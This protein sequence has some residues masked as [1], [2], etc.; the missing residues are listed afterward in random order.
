KL[1]PY[2][3]EL[4]FFGVMPQ[5]GPDLEHFLHANS[6]LRSFLYVLR[7]LFRQKW[8]ELRYGRGL[9][10]SNGNALVARLVKSATAFGVEIRTSAPVLQLTKS[11]GRVDG[12]VIA[13]ESGPVRVR[14]TRGV[15]L[16]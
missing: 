5:I 9:V 1:R 6:S 2:M 4:T 7:R 3:E 15:V 14:A 10:L 11:G 13:T 16:A 8:E 12:A